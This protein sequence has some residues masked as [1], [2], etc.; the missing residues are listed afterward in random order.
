MKLATSASMIICLVLSACATD[1]ASQLSGPNFGRTGLKF[2]EE[3]VDPTQL[4][5]GTYASKQMN[6]S[7]VS[8]PFGAF[9]LSANGCSQRAPLWSSG[10]VP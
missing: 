6:E 9:C 10:W 1:Y 8:R 3:D 5:N 4:M 7:S 2:V